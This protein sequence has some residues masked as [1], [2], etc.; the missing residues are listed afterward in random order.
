MTA[1]H[2][3]LAVYVTNHDMRVYVSV[4]SGFVDMLFVQG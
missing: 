2:F 3:E 4:N 1:E